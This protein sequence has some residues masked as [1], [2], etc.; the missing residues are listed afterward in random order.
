MENEENYIEF[1]ENYLAN[2]LS[3]DEVK[4]FE[5]LRQSDDQFNK[6]FLDVKTI[7][8]GIRYSTRKELKGSLKSLGFN[9]YSNQDLEP[10][11]ELA[12]QVDLEEKYGVKISPK[13]G[14]QIQLKQESQNNRSF[15]L[16][17]YKSMG[18]AASIALLIAAYFIFST[19]NSERLYNLAYN[20]IGQ[21]PYTYINSDDENLTVV[22]GSESEK[23]E[24]QI[25]KA[26]NAYSLGQYET[27]I[28]S[29]RELLSKAE[30]DK[31]KF[32]L[33]N[34]YLANNQPE[35]SINIFKELLENNPGEFETRTKWYLGI[36]FLKNGEIDEAKVV[37]MDLAKNGG[38]SYQE[39]A[40]KLL[41]EF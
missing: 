29:F 34:A 31:L 41:K 5:S 39:K 40:E 7:L 1:I 23:V 8:P 9:Q 38:D 24:D 30:D 36:S 35:E 20:E 14:K 18:I 28:N 6:L 25:Q 12:D 17:T 19:P 22:R 15:S 26:Y 21:G 33:G 3:T 16:F 11:L 10:F 4:E 32:Y 2:K 27:S 13:E 37:F